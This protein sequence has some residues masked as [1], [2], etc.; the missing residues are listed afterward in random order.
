MK[1][2]HNMSF[3]YDLKSVL[4]IGVDFDNWVLP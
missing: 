4:K 3:V 1:K 2:T